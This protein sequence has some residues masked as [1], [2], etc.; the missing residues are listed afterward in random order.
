MAPY[1]SCLL[2]GQNR[3]LGAG[4]Q[5]SPRKSLP[6][7]LCPLL[8]LPSYVATDTGT[9]KSHPGKHWGVWSLLAV[10]SLMGGR[11][12]VGTTWHHLGAAMQ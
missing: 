3:G 4:G 10:V 7:T 9:L 1:H 12:G 6:K 2:E 5:L 11:G 8:S